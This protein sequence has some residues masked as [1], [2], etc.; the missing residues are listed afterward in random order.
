MHIAMVPPYANN[1][2]VKFER[3]SIAHYSYRINV[4]WFKTVD[5]QILTWFSTV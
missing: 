2:Y 5:I 4:T 1:R 3:L